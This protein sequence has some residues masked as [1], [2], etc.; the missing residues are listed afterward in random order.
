MRIQLA[1]NVDD[2]EAA[3]AYYSKL[4]D[5]E[6]HKRKPGYANFALDEPPLKLV[7][8]EN[9]NA[10]E[11]LNHLGVEV[12]DSDS[13]E[14][15]TQRLNEHGITEETEQ[16]RVCCYAKQDKVWSRDPSGLRWEWYTVL[17]DSSSWGTGEREER[18]SETSLGKGA[19]RE[20]RCCSGAD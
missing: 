8:L 14:R 1:L 11:R 3:V 18:G 4:F 6:P 13:V 17:E 7:L 9:P 19:T 10:G 16:A 20:G 15:A 2:L 12:A 5:A